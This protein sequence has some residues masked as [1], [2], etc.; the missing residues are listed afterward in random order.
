MPTRAERIRTALEAAFP[1]ARIIVQDDSYRHAGHAGARPEG[2]THYSVQ[3]V[4]PAFAGQSRL[5]RS[6]AVH[7]VLAAEFGGGLHALSLRLLT[8]EEA[9]EG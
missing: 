4:S 8:P 5:T 6:R 9:G 2:E 7:A 3:V 1:P